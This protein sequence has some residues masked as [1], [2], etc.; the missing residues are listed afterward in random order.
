MQQTNDACSLDVSNN[1]AQDINK[2]KEQSNDFDYA[3]LSVGV[4]WLL[5]RLASQQTTAKMT[6][7]KEDFRQQI[8]GGKG[9]GGGGGRG[10]GGGGGGGSRNEPNDNE[11]PTP[12]SACKLFA[13]MDSC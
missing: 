5:Q 2:E 3:S 4:D 10:D 11:T 9:G 6:T 8:N 1:F 12:P 7:G 13:M